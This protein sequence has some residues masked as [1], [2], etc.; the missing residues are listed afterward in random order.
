MTKEP[1]FHSVNIE[2]YAYYRKQLKKAD[3]TGYTKADFKK[4]VNEFSK[5]MIDKLI[6]DGILYLPKKLGI[7]RI[8]GHKVI[9]RV[10]NDKIVNLT[11]NYQ[12]T[13]KQKKPIYEFNEHSNGI[14][15]RVEWDKQAIIGNTLFYFTMV[16]D[17]KRQ[18]SKHIKE[19]KAHYSIGN[20]RK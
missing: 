8:I 17:A 16:R 4:R 12:E 2:G 15:Y 1:A 13:R 14:R 6:E 3:R 10:V 5:Y 9:A 7:I 11:L 19:G 18:L 20:T